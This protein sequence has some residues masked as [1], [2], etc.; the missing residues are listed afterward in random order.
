MERIFIGVAWPYANGSLHLGTLAGALLP[1]DI[2]GRYN[3]MKGN[4]VLMVSGSDEH[5]TP[6]TLTAEKEERE[7][8]KIVDRYH[9]EHVKNLKELGIKFENFSRT[10]NEFHK[11]V[12]KN[13]FL[14]LYEK[15]YIYPK[16]INAFFCPKC[17]RFLPD[18][19]IEGKCPYCGG[20]ARGDQCEE[21]GATLE[22]TELI[23]PKCKI[24]GSTPIL[25]ET[26]HLFFKLSSFEGQLLKW[27]KGK[28]YWRDNVLQFTLNFIKSGLKDRAI[29]RDLKWGVEVPL[30]GYENKRIYVWFDAVIGYL[31]ASME[32]AEKIGKKDEWKKWWMEDAKHYYFLAKDNIP[33]HTIIWPAM[34]MAHGDLNLPYDVPAN[35]YLLLSGK[36]FSKSR[37]IGIWIPDILKKFEADTIRYYLSINM[38][39]KHDTDWKWDDFVAKINNELV[40]VYGNYIHRVLT[41]VYKNFGK[42]PSGNENEGKETWNEVVKNIKGIGDSIEKCHFKE[43]MKKIMKIAQLGNQ[44]LNSSKPWAL[45]KEDRKKC[46][47]VM[48]LC[49]RIVRS[50][51]I[52]SSPYMPITS[53]KIWKMIGYNDDIYT[54]KWDD[55][56][57]DIEEQSIEKPFPLFKKIE[58]ADIIEEPFSKLDIRV[59]KIIEA[60][61]HPNADKL[62][63]LDIDVGSF[64]KRKIVAGLKEWYSIDD[65]NG[66]KILLLANLKPA[67]LRGIKSEGM[68]L[69]AD[70]GKRAYLLIPNDEPGSKVYIDGLKSNPAREI[71]YQEFRKIKILTKDGKVE[72][73]GRF[74]KDGKGCIKIDGEVG[75]GLIIR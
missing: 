21:C 73:K 3:R 71:S 25:K 27:L 60:R 57:N 37:G 23:D 51:A 46:G 40:A 43:G 59:A 36:Q 29:T 49:T 31:S 19:Y 24:C 16:K 26:E 58:L 4:E 15:G 34:L 75:D 13:F 55:A 63:V 32:W 10:S 35:E 44:Y 7:P 17:N 65:L 38:P 28:E 41:F 33:F 56:L 12:V 45:I 2:F 70:D 69:A 39:E 64:G 30:K 67:N 42:I 47:Y 5:G 50:L 22:P 72:Y 66:R 20:R 8:K 53:N 74:L 54:H 18:R 6:I 11:N 52:V 48:H 68:L 1:G 62:Y 9:E 14:K 61:L